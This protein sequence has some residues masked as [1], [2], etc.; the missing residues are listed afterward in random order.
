LNKPLLSVFMIILLFAA[1]VMSLNIGKAYGYERSYSETISQ[2]T[3][4]TKANSP[5]NLPG[6]VLVSKDAT[7]TIEAGVTVNC[8]KNVIQVNGTLKVQGTDQNKVVFTSTNTQINDAREQLANINFGDDSSGSSIQY[9]VF[10]TMAWTY[11]NCKNSILIDHVTIQD[12]STATNSGSISVLPTIRGSG[13]AIITNSVFTSG[14]QLVISSTVI[15]NTF[16]DAGISASDGSFTITN[17]TLIGTTSPVQGFGISIERCQKAVIADN[18]ITNYVEACIKID[19]PAI[20]L[21]NYIESRPNRD[22]YPFFGLQV[23]GSSPLIENNTITNAGIGIDLYDQGYILTRPTIKNNNIYSNVNF[24]LYMGY[25]ARPGYKPE[26]YSA[27][28]S[29]DA[30]G[31]YWGSTDGQAI[32]Q[33]IHDSRFQLDLGVVHFTEFL[34]APNSQAMPNSNLPTPTL[35]Q[36]PPAKYYQ[37]TTHSNQNVILTKIGNLTIYPN[38]RINVTTNVLSASTNIT[39]LMTTDTGH[40]DFVNIT[41]PKSAIPYGTNP[42]VYFGNQLA[43]NQSYTQDADNYYVWCTT[44]FSESFFGTGTIVFANAQATQ[45]INIMILG[46]IAAIIIVTIAALTIFWRRRR[47]RLSCNGKLS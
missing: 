12:G 10:H 19:G 32:S 36:V 8:N 45:T 3:T 22:G 23:E 5:I 20:I 11:Y 25:P 34:T 47:K 15:N 16:S 17:N 2:D 42:K 6:N 37:A 46:I 4:W 29:I 21:R 30:N 40:N 28:S 38:D 14:F 35:D 9:A 1:F 27:R 44:G 31:N 7:L 13:N 39:F 33:T 26:D 18:Y 41:V 24:N 43:Q